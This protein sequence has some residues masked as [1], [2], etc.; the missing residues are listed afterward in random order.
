[1]KAGVVLDAWKLP[2]FKRHLDDAGY[3]YTEAPALTRK[4][5]TLVVQCEWAHKLQAVIEA[6]EAECALVRK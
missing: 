2:V 6:A 5:V 1:M 3:A 4:T